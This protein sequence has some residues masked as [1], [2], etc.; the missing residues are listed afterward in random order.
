MTSAGGLFGR[1]LYKCCKKFP[2]REGTSRTSF[3]DQ[4]HCM[5]IAYGSLMET[6]C[7]S[8]LAEDPGYFT[9]ADQGHLREQV[10]C[11]ANKLNALRK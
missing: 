11:P 8:T 2:A 10:Q 3:K 9:S 1:T 4:A 6:A 5:Q 7:L